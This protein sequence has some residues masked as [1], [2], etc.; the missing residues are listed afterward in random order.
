M[1]EGNFNIF[2]LKFPF[3]LK[4]SNNTMSTKLQLKKKTRHKL[5]MNVVPVNVSLAVNIFSL[6]RSSARP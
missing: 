6:V 1:T 5:T 2:Y 3:L 4:M